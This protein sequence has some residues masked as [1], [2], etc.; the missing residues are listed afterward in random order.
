LDGEKEN[1][2]DFILKN[3]N[4]YYLVEDKC[5][6]RQ[7]KKGQFKNWNIYDNLNF[8]SVSFMTGKKG[9]FKLFFFVSFFFS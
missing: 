2:E 1:K 4:L 9:Q 3:W 8:S 6:K 5:V 7:G